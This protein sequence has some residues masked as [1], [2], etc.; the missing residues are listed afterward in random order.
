MNFVTTAF[1]KR[2]KWKD[3]LNLFMKEWSHIN[4]NF[5]TTAVLK[6]VVIKHIL[7]LFIRKRKN[8]SVKGSM[9]KKNMWHLSMKERSH[10][11]LIFVTMYCYSWK[12]KMK[13]HV[14][15]VHTPTWGIHLSLKK[16]TQ[17]NRCYFQYLWE[18]QNH[19]VKKKIL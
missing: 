16:N 15:S 6:R 8:C 1:P 7:H 17:L 12:G 9:K 10:I 5:V 19:P 13:I 11:N 3:M 4:E 18:K 2:A 14:H